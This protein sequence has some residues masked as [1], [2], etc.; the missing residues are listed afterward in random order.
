MAEAFVG[1]FRVRASLHL[2]S[3]RCIVLASHE[4][5]VSSVAHF[6]VCVGVLSRC[7]SAYE[8]DSSLIYLLFFAIL[9]KFVLQIFV[10]FLTLEV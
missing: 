6:F 7:F 5:F 3:V 2:K 9:K 10:F 8:G 4:F 1:F